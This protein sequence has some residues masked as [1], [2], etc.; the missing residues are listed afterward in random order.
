MKF[1]KTALIVCVLLLNSLIAFPAWADAGKYIKTPEYTEVTQAIADLTDPAKRTDLTPTAIQQKLADLRFQQYILETS[2][3]R[4]NC[5]NETDKTLAVYARPKK[6]AVAPTLYFLGAGE[7]I[8][9]DVECSGIYLPSGSKVVAGAF[10]Q[11]L[12]NPTAIKFVPGTQLVATANPDTG[13]IQLNAPAFGA[14][15]EGEIDWSI[16]TFSPAEVEAQ[17]PNAPVD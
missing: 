3:G 2:E 9:D 16:P 4:S 8:D 17:T 1:F 6:A 5:R 14:F 12:T 15:Q 13:E 10:A 11:E 7:A